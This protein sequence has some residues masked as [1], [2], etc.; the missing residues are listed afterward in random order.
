MT[1]LATFVGLG[2]ILLFLPIDEIVEVIPRISLKNLFLGLI[3]YTA[4]YLLRTLRWKYY[5]PRAGL[6][7]L[8]FTTS[9]NTFLNNLFP[10]RLGE[11]SIL[12]LLRRYDK[13]F[14]TTIGKFLKVRLLDGFTILTFL[15]FAVVSIKTNFFL[16]LILALF[17]YP[18]GL[19]IANTLRIFKK[20]PQISWEPLP[21]LLSI[22]ALLTKLLAIYVILESLNLDFLHFTVGF[23]GGEIS[24]VMPIHSIAGIGSYETS[25]SLA[26]KL[27]LGENFKEGFM[28][29]FFSHAF[30]LL[31]S[32]LLGLLSLPFVLR[33]LR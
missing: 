19:V 18:F 16:G 24:T 23:L 20:I 3:L 21:F 30:L 5:Y 2:L 6:G 1:I 32:T 27:L 4:S 9:V 7:E 8:F 15:T 17:I 31:G 12:A 14:K 25:F 10:A 28:V 22:G 33:F 13:D 29:A 11:L 26:L